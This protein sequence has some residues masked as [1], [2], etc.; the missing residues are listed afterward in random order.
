MQGL[1]QPLHALCI[2]SSG[3]YRQCGTG[4]FAALAAEL[5]D[6]GRGL[7]PVGGPAECAM[8]QAILQRLDAALRTCVLAVTDGTVADTVVVMSL[9]RACLGNNTGGAKVAAA[10][11]TA[12]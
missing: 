5:A 2:G 4:N 12:T 7:L 8:G 10:A 6:A 1:P 9:V 3:P 11:G